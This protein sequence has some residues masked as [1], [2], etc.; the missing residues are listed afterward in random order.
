MTSAWNGVAPRRV[1]SPSGPSGPAIPLT[2]SVPY[3][4][5]TRACSPSAT[6]SSSGTTSPTRWT[7]L[8]TAGA[9]LSAALGAVWIKGHYDDRA[10]A[11]QAEQNR[12]IARE[13]QQRQA[14]GELVKTAR[15]ALRNFRQLGL[16][17]AA[18]TPDIP[19]VNEAFSQTASLAADM[20]QTAALAELVGSPAGR[21]HARAIYDKATACAN[22]FQI[23]ELLLAAMPNTA[24]GNSSQAPCQREPHP[25]HHHFR[26][27]SGGCRS[28]D[29]DGQPP[30]AMITACPADKMHR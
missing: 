4:S 18:N 12:T 24:V 21:K 23:R 9:T 30:W 6:F 7:T 16:A 1:S 27:W 3:T 11:R 2:G 20:N 10:Q 25:P 5:R 19:A 13:D 29:L 15:L 17:Y 22:L 14:Y 8:I 26:P 28:I